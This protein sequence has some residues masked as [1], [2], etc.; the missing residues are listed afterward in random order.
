MELSLTLNEAQQM[1]INIRKSL[2]AVFS[3]VGKAA[4][5]AQSAVAA[6]FFIKEKIDPDVPEKKPVSRKRKRKPDTAKSLKENI[7]KKPSNED[8]Q[9]A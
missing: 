9:D 1:L 3:L 8:K 2:G 6:Y 4:T 5:A 7:A